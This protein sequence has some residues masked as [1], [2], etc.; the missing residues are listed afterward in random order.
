MKLRLLTPTFAVARLEGD[1]LPPWFS[2]A[3]PFACAARR[4]DEL[5]LVCLEDAVPGAV[6]AERGWR[7]L[8]VEGPLDFSLTGVLSAL[9]APLAEDEISIFALST[10]DTDVLLVRATRL[11]DAVASLEAEGHVIA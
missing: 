11:D 6:V 3:A 7:A 5:S 8:E 1:E 10:Y 2:F 9:A 4:D